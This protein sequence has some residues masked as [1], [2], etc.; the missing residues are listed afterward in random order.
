MH[1]A[2]TKKR[3]HDSP[4]DDIE[5]SLYSSFSSAANGI[6]LLYTQVRARECTN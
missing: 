1:R 6:S 3:K 4:L 2:S 5:R